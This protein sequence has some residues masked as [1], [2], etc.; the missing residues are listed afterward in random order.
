MFWNEFTATSIGVIVAGVAFWITG[1][2][3]AL[4]TASSDEATPPR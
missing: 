4:D 3:H 1:K 2:H